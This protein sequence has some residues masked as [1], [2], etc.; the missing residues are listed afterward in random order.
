M[1]QPLP[2]GGTGAGVAEQRWGVQHGKGVGSRV[3]ME[4]EE[5]GP[6]GRLE[7][8]G[9]AVFPLSTVK[10]L[11]CNLHLW[12]SQPADTSSPSSGRNPGIWQH[13]FTVWGQVGRAG[14]M[15]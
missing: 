13:C 12:S 2:G 14:G 11:A 8:G 1:G 9:V 5:G 6:G 15:G 3:N 4:G 10:T 7:G